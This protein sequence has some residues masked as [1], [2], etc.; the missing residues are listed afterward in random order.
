MAND[1]KPKPASSGWLVK[2]TLIVFFAAL[3]TAGAHIAFP[4]GPIPISMQNLFILLSGLVLGPVMGS[5]AVI[6]YLLAGVLNLPVFALGGGGISRFTGPAGGY[7]IGYLLAAFTA[8]LIAGRPKAD[9]SAKISQRIIIAEIAG[10]LISYVPGLFWLKIRM[11][12]DW[13]KTFQTGLIPFIIG[14]P[15]KGIA[16]VFIAPRLRRIVAGFLDNKGS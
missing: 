13:A 9:E 1:E 5:A 12:L 6:L 10:L 14:D 2:I 16:A 3:T 7:F 8:G 11:N 4:I 15:I